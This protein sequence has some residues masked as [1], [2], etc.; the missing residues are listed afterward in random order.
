MLAENTHTHTHTHA[1]THVCQRKELFVWDTPTPPP[2]LT[3]WTFLRRESGDEAT[4]K[5]GKEPKEEG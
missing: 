5:V 2:S 1:L 3:K 4:H